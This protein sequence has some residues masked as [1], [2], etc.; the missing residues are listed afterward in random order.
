L[1]QEKPAG[2]AADVAM[3]R[4]VRKSRVSWTTMGDLPDDREDGL[5]NEVNAA[6]EEL[7]YVMRVLATRPGGRSVEMRYVA[8]SL[9]A[10]ADSER[11]RRQQW[12]AVDDAIGRLHAARTRHEAAA[13][14]EELCRMMLPGVPFA[15]AV[16]ASARRWI[17]R[18][19]AAAD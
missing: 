9:L 19:R 7:R 17:A 8:P 3:R 4:F 12:A 16:C 13:T 6:A 2:R 5:E 14:L 11:A 1:I 15:A 10:S 18:W